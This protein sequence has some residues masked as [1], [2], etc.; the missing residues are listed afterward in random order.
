[1]RRAGFTLLELLLVI[2]AISIL[3]ALAIPN[4]QPSLCEQLQGTA[5]I[6]ATDLAYARSLAVSNNDRYSITWDITNHRYILQ[7]SGTNAALN[8]LPLSPFSAP[9]DP[10]TQHIVNFDNL[11]H[12]G[13]T[14]KLLAVGTSGNSPSPVASLEFGPLGGTTSSLAT[15]VWLTAG[16]VADQRYI[17]ISVDPVTGLATIG[18]FTTAGPPSSLLH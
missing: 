10:A 2:A 9:G 4:T 16:S 12:V 15:I 11:P 13:P 3:S 7:H 1:M 14:V 18:A 6:V 8:T 17:T 5:Q